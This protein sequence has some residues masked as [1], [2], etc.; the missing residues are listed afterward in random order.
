MNLCV[1][2]RV[3]PLVFACLSVPCRSS[4]SPFAPSLPRSLPP[5]HP[6]S[7]PCFLPLI[8]RSPFPLPASL[9]SSVVV[10]KLVRA[11][12]V[13]GTVHVLC[14]LCV[15]MR[16]DTRLNTLAPSLSPPLKRPTTVSKETYHNTLAPSLSPPLNLCH[17]VSLPLPFTTLWSASLSSLYSSLSPFLCR[18]RQTRKGAA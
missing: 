16:S 17:P 8:A 10:V 7:R 3:H 15:H 14:V 1:R 12:A 5:F 11:S 4:G 2:V 13:F 9:F 6:L 18:R